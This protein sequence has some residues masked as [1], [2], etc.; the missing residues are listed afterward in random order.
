MKKLSLLFAILLVASAT[1]FTSCS[2]D[3]TTTPPTIMLN[4]GTGYT[5]TDV[6]VP[7]NTALK[8]GVIANSTT[9]KLT[10]L[11]VS[12]TI[13]GVTTN[14]SDNTFAT[15]TATHNEDFEMTASP[16]AGVVTLTFR[17]TADDGEYAEAS[18]TITTTSAPINTY[19]AVLLGGQENPNLGSFYST[20]DN[21]VMKLA[22]ARS[23][24]QTVDMVYYYGTTNHA[25]IVAVSDNQLQGVP[26]FVECASWPTQNETK[27]KLTTGVD[28]STI[29]DESGILA[30]ATDLTVTHINQLA[31]GDIVSFQ[32]A[33]TSSNPSKKGMY[34][35]M[36]VNG[37]GGADRSITIEVKIQK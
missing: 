33:T 12:Q 11:K 16:V 5:A 9:G 32:T 7:V 21:A 37:T 10:N 27:F 26:S 20:I 8:I 29:T 23:N 36:E 3:T 25:S 31:V 17:I 35:V 34:K 14:I 2:K 13:S 28:W 19:T 1:F 4:A 30:N 22:A 18:L 15:P 24:S 6:S